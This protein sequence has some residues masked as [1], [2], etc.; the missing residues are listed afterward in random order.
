MRIAT[1]NLFEGAQDT[2]PLVQDFVA[3]QDVDVLCVQEANGWNDGLPSQLETLAAETGLNAY[4]YGDSNTRF[5]LATLLRLPILRSQV[6]TDGFWHSAVQTTI[7]HG[8]E[9]LD[10]WNVHLNPGD[11]DSR[12]A[13]A[14]LL[15]SLVDMDKPTI[16]MG[17]FNSLNESDKYP[18]ELISNLALQG[19][20]KFGTDK[21]RYDV[22]AYFTDKGLIDVAA[23]LGKRQT[24]VPTP[25]NRDMYHA[26]NMRLDY[27]FATA[28]LIKSVVGIEV[29]KDNLTDAISDHYP[30]ILTLV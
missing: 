7:Q 8:D 6:H 26:A 21:L 20:K 22:T 10:L 30:V 17:D 2:L 25:A 4:V 16:I 1:Y 19:I 18:D 23:L 13:E 24:T 14:T 29:P 3:Q 11:E 9:T 28:S 15:T 5:K 12:L 27:M